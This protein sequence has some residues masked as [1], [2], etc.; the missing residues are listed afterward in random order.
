MPF[1]R[2]FAVQLACYARGMKMN[3]HTVAKAAK[4]LAI[5]PGAV[6]DAIA[7][8]KTTPVRVDGGSQ[9]VGLLLIPDGQIVEYREKYLGKRGTYRRHRSGVVMNEATET[10]KSS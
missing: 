10:G 2:I 7:K 3:M 8:G 6:R 4:Q 5:T 9:R 1:S